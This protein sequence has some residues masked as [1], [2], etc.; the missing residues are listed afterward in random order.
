MQE[1][2]D[3]PLQGYR[4]TDQGYVRIV[5]DASAAL[6]S[7][8]LG[9]KLRIEGGLLQ[10]YRV[11]T[12]ERLLTADERATYEAEARQAAEAEVVRLRDELAR[13]SQA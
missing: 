8:Q 4:L 7:E 12:G 11:D 10:F 1:Y 9:L 2:L 3:P 5:P 13:R 6:V